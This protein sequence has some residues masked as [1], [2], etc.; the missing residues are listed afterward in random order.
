M[1][2]ASLINW[3]NLGI[4]VFA[5]VVWELF[6]RLWIFKL[7][8]KVGINIEKENINAYKPWESIE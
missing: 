5:I 2:L 7:L 8:S 1:D 3:T 6:L 4:M